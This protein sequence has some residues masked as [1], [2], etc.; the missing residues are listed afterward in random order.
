MVM[1][2]PGYAIYYHIV[3]ANV[4]SALGVPGELVSSAPHLVVEGGQE[5]VAEQWRD[6]AP[7]AKDS[8]EFERVVPLP[9][10]WGGRSGR[11]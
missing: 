1:R 3:S 9:R 8:F 10:R 7:Y 2:N 4:T 6:D 11:A 5:D